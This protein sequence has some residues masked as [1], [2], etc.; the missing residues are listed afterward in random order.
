MENA[1]IQH[2]RSEKWSSSL[3]SNGYVLEN[4]AVYEES[5]RRKI[6]PN[7]SGV[8]NPASFYASPDGLSFKT[9]FYSGKVERAEEKS[10]YSWES[11][12]EFETGILSASFSP[13]SGSLVVV[14]GERVFLLDKFFNPVRDELLKEEIKKLHLEK[15][16]PIQITFSPDGKY[17]AICMGTVISVYTYN[18]EPVS[19]TLSVCNKIM[20]SRLMGT[21][22]FLLDEGAYVN[23]VRRLPVSGEDLPYKEIAPKKES[24]EFE[25]RSCYKLVTWH[26]SL[27][28]MYAVTHENRIHVLE[29]NSLKFYEI[30]HIRKSDAEKEKILENEIFFISARICYLY[31][32]HKENKNF[33]LKVF[34]VKNNVIYLKCNFPV[35][36]AVSSPVHEVLRMEVGESGNI[37]IV[38]PEHIISLEQTTFVNR[39]RD[40]VI[41]IDGARLFFYN[42]QKCTIPPPMCSQEMGMDGVPSDMHVS[43]D[44]EISCKINGKKQIFSGPLPKKENSG[45]EFKKKTIE[46]S[47]ENSPVEVEI[48]P[49]ECLVSLNTRTHT[50]KIEHKSTCVEMPRITSACPIFLE[51]EKS[52]VVTRES[53]PWT[54][55]VRFYAENGE[56]LQEKLARTGQSS[57]IVFISETTVILIDRYGMLESFYIPALV[58]IKVA[59]LIK[60]GQVESAIFTLK[61]Y[62]MPVGPWLQM[63]VYEKEA[64]PARIL[65]EIVRFLGTE[66]E[67]EPEVDKIEKIALA[68]IFDLLKEE[69]VKKEEIYEWCELCMEIHHLKNDPAQLVKFAA[70]FTQRQK[71]SPNSLSWRFYDNNHISDRIIRKTI[72]VFS[73]EI[74]LTHAMN[75]YKYTLCYIILNATNTPMDVVNDT[76]LPANSEVLDPFSEHEEVER[77]LRISKVSKNK[78]SQ[79]FYSIKTCIGA[80]AWKEAESRG[81]SER[82]L[83]LSSL[84]ASL[85]KDVARDFYFYLENAESFFESEEV[86]EWFDGEFQEAV[87]SL[88]LLCGDALR[89]END[90]EDALW[91]YLRT[92]TPNNPELK[93]LKMQLGKWRELFEDPAE[94]TRERVEKME[95]VLLLQKNTLAAAE[96][97]LEVGCPV[98][99]A[100]FLIDLEMFSELKF[101]ILKTAPENSP[102]NIFKAKETTRAEFLAQTSEYLRKKVQS[103][104]ESSES[105]AGTY[106]ENTQR[107]HRVRERKD[108]E[109]KKVLEGEFEPGDALTVYTRSFITN[110]LVTGNSTGK[111]KRSSKLRNTVGGRY[112]EEYVQYVLSE[113]ILKCKKH[114]KNMQEIES[115]FSCADMP[116]GE[117]FSH[118]KSAFKKALCT[119]YDLCNSSISEDFVSLNSE[120]DVLYDPERPLIEQP[121]ISDIKAYVKEK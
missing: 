99:G 8:K 102:E 13:G 63:L 58:K 41:D 50:L 40:N 93:K 25:A 31:L 107:L 112:E 106:R 6:T 29:R 46:F 71:L 77:R 96:M 48:G 23:T 5:S 28:K 83:L 39:S 104:A 36:D 2:T 51:E 24:V 116:G 59:N 54:E 66:P 118:E 17:I 88:L 98:K 91:C 115:I 67:I 90:L 60:N 3:T 45:T 117:A 110:T 12:G 11:V 79:T 89:R 44:G 69:T 92:K 72:G 65:L 85:E 7:N 100:K 10:G 30:F 70:L 64:V 14:T 19:D 49:M 43:W 68:K 84:K 101:F 1:R 18:L 97:H 78:K 111:K 38:T 80:S 37:R 15:F 74:L 73:A 26:C 76:L 82:D 4:G 56:I 20:N 103:F 119:F 75:S 61:K 34:Y 55:I 42:L 81:G 53:H 62:G 114:V 120:D 86:P 52:L 87:D 16:S 105:A 94:R 121:D 21:K 47:S 33:Y 35:N 95:E 57:K 109:R 9:V 113:L 27:P 22:K 32:L 108:G